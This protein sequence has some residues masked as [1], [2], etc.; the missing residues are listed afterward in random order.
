M[1]NKTFKGK[2]SIMIKRGKIKSKQ[3]FESLRKAIALKLG[4]YSGIL[5]KIIHRDLQYKKIF[6]PK[7]CVFLAMTRSNKDYIG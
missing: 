4:I 2:K 6:E 5:I 3:S 1:F 7:F